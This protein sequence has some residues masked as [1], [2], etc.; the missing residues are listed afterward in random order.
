MNES[1]SGKVRSHVRR[2][3]IAASI[4]G[5]LLV[6]LQLIA[7]STDYQYVFLAS[8][9]V[10]VVTALVM[11]L[12][13]QRASSKVG[14]PWRVPCVAL[15]LAVTA[16]GLVR[17]KTLSGEMVP[18]L[19]WRF[20]SHSVP[21]LQRASDIDTASMESPGGETI[22]DV[23]SVA[24]EAG[25]TDDTDVSDAPKWTPVW[26][27]FLGNERDGILAKREFEVPESAGEAEQL[28]TIG[29]GGG[30]ASFAIAMDADSNGIAVTLEQ[31]EERE[32]VTA[33]DL[34][35]GKLLW[36]VDHNASHFNALGEGGPRSTPTI[37]NDRVYAQG[38][39]GTVW[40]LDLQTGSEV[41]KRDLLEAGGWDQAASE[42]AI[43]WGR[44]GSPLVVDG[45]C[46]LPM[47]GTD[48]L[49]AR[50]LIAMDVETGETVWTAGEGQISYASPQLL[51]LGGQ[52]RIVSVNE[53]DITGHEIT[54]GEVLWQTDWEGQSNGGSNC[55]SVIPAGQDR[56]LIG[57]GY[58]GGSALIE[59]RRQDDGWE[60]EDVWRT[61]RVLKTKFNHCVTRDGVAYGISNGALQAVD[62]ESAERL[63]EQGRRGR[64]GQGQVILVDDILIVQAEMGDVAIVEAN[65]NDFVELIRFDALQQKTWNIPSVAGNLLLVRN[66]EQAIAFRLPTR[67]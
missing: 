59:V 46:V 37:F 52:R 4:G 43:T 30:W 32:C 48:Q 5:V 35:T 2:A 61:T 18:Q 55:S 12:Q 6:G 9:V 20:A 39:T 45:M 16:V 14:H 54:T 60:V 49:S 50:S 10:G 58:G 29:I 19:E 51:T 8:L 7:P 23:A 17:V 63:W 53:A 42:V 41:W 11:L 3:A 62:V 34:M 24:D 15:L 56:F 64:Y 47:G 65:P 67:P 28:W 40:C 21:E 36:L 33:Y 27:Q 31:R 26:G 25:K 1:S 22:D 57:K 38:A 44:S 13:L 66:A